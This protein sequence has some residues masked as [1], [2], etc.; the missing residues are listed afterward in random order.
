MKRGNFFKVENTDGLHILHWSGGTGWHIHQLVPTWLD[1]TVEFYH[2]PSLFYYRLIMH[3][4]QPTTPNYWRTV[5]INMIIIWPL[6]SIVGQFL[7]SPEPFGW[8]NRWSNIK[9]ICKTDSWLTLQK[10]SQRCC[11]WLH[12][13]RGVG[14]RIVQL[15]ARITF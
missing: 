1:S 4:H 2:P 3:N 14:V 7:S 15:G 12:T 9:H 13:N 11:R 5:H 6:T 8:L 10:A